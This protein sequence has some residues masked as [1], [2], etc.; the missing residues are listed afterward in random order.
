MRTAVYLRQSLDKTGEGLAV[1]RQREDCLKLCAERG[2]TPN[3]YVDNDTSATKG[4]R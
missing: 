1:D 4:V 3:E 2:W